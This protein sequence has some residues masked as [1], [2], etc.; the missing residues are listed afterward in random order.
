MQTCSLS[1]AM[2]HWQKTD[3]GHSTLSLIDINSIKS[4]SP[5]SVRNAT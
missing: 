3:G 5:L 2:S 1:V 4:T